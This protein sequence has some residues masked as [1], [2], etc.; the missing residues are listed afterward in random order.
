MAHN[1]F[2]CGEVDYI[3]PDYNDWT[4]IDDVNEQENFVVITMS[5][6]LLTGVTMQRKLMWIEPN[7]IIIIDTAECQTERGF[8]QNFMLD[9]FNVYKKDKQKVSIDASLE[10]T[11]TITQFA[12]D[13]AD[14][15]LT[16]HHGTT[17]IQDE[18]NL[19]GTLIESWE[20]PKKGLCLA[21]TKKGKGAQFITAIELQSTSEKAQEY[22]KSVSTVS[23]EAGRLLVTLA[24]GTIVSETVR[25][26]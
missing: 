25:D 18:A 2:I 17:N 4:T 23:I 20:K 21:Y 9:N 6:R 1:A 10:I 5:H 13:G 11:A 8:T 14:F 24:D 19:R 26:E 16:E 12:A 22:Q 15:A 7:I 3:T